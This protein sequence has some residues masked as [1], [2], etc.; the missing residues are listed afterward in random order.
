MVIKERIGKAPFEDDAV[1]SMMD[2]IQKC[3]VIIQR[4][5]DLIKK[6]DM[7]RGLASLSLG[8]KIH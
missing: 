4:N 3:R 2:S 7:D 5:A 8:K 1:G 6:Q